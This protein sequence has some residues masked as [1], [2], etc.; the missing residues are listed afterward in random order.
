MLVR[1]FQCF[2]PIFIAPDTTRTTKMIIIRWDV[3]H[4]LSLLDL[5]Y[6]KYYEQTA[7]VLWGINA[8]VAHGGSVNA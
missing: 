1:E 7:C 6:L 3:V 8:D 5:H 2:L 4:G